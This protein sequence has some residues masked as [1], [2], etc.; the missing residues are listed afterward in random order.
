MPERLPPEPSPA[1]RAL[2]R[3]FQEHESPSPAAR[4]HGWDA[5][6]ARLH[7]EPSPAANGRR[8]VLVKSTAV[9]VAIAA[10]VLLALKGVGAGVTA[11]ADQARQPAMEAPYQG[12]SASDG[13]QAVPRAPRVLPSRT[14]AAATASEHEAAVLEAP[15]LEAPELEEPMPTAVT[16]PSRPRPA[17]PSAAPASSPADDLQ[18]E[19][20][21]IKRANE[22]KQAGR[23]ADGLAVL[24]EHAERFARG[25]LADERMVLRAELEC[26]SGRAREARELAERFLRERAGSA[27]A[28]RMRGVCRSE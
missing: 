10:V 23:H 4:T 18:A 12:G 28:G 17:A 2:L 27:L 14:S 9:A 21:L 22:A 11:L 19:L 7:A 15:V 25:T 1:A 13:G 20:A 26:A 8:Y 6:Q 5:L 24:R 3:A 16:R